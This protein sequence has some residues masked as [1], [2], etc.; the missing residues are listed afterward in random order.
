[1]LC[2]CN[3]AGETFSLKKKYI[4]TALISK[5]LYFVRMVFNFL[6]LSDGRNSDFFHEVMMD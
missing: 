4:L 5:G 6:A 3:K 1:M 2:S